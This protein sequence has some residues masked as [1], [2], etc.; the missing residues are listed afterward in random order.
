[1]IG[2]YVFDLSPNLK[3]KPAV[4]AKVVQG[5]PVAVDLSANFLISNK[6]TLGA[7]YRLNASVSGMAGFQV[8]DAIQ[9]GYA[10][11][12]ET[13]NLGRYNSGSHEL[14]L[15]FDFLSKSKARLVT[16]RFF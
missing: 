9:I 6:L 5:A 16:P 11:D 7:A 3:F 13:T 1:M 4:L 12:Y 14:F 2:G 8:S 15:R 10:Y